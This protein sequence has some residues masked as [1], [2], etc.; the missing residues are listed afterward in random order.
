VAALS[1]TVALAIAAQ[2]MIVLHVQRR[3]LVRAA[4]RTTLTAGGG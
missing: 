2:A 1:V 4:W 3:A